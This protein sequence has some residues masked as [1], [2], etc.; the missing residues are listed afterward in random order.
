[1][2]GRN[3]HH[4]AA[5]HNASHARIHARQ[6]HQKGGYKQHESG[7][8][9]PD[10]HSVS[11]RH[12][13]IAR[14][15][16]ASTI[17]STFLNGGSVDFRIEKGIMDVI[18]HAYLQ[19]DITNGTGASTTIAPL[20]LAIDRIEVWGGNGS[21]LLTTIQGQ[22]AF[23]S[24]AFLSRDEWEQ[25]SAYFASTDAY[26]TAGEALA[27]GTSKVYIVPV[28]HLL[29]A[30]QLFM[31]GLDSEIIVRVVMQTSTY[32]ILSGSNP[33][34][35]GVYLQLKGVAEPD[36]VRAKRLQVY[37]NPKSPLLLP[38]LN[39]TRMNQTL[40]LATSSEYSIILS[41]LK[42]FVAAIFFTIRASPLTGANQG[43]Y[44][45]IASYELQNADGSGLLGSYRR[46]HTDSKLDAGE[47]F[48]NLFN[49]NKNFYCIPM[50]ESISADYQTG[51]N[52][53]YQVLDGFQKLSFT[54]N[55]SITP[56]AFIVD[57]RALTYEHLS[58]KNGV[59]SSSKN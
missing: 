32:T 46:T 53:G 51:Q 48:H 7:A 20:Q 5:H 16:P 45:A 18:T 23:L 39:W 10:H 55:S 26:S 3:I 56:G 4:R 30:I 2:S 15:S 41:G 47:M 59:L 1:M 14:Q 19:F 9:M 52:S 58:V 37:R 12:R 43:T 40:T 35:N 6:T 8:I 21:T 44:Q 38:Y 22:E 24:N 11:N 50:S 42:G 31:A 27:D 33:T 13:Q 57:I 28:I 34:T 25:T 17:A 54:T 29:P 36:D 49:E